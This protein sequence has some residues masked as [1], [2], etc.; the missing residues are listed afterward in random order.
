MKSQVTISQ[1]NSLTVINLI[2]AHRLYLHSMLTIATCVF[3][4]MGIANYVYPSQAIAQP[5]LLAQST[6]TNYGLGLPKSASTGGGTRLVNRDSLEIDKNSNTQPRRGVI[7][8]IRSRD[9]SPALLMRQLQPQPLLTL[10][11][12]ED[13][14]RTANAQPTLYWY[15]YDQP[16]Q[17]ASSTDKPDQPVNE[18]DETTHAIDSQDCFVGQLRIILT[19]DQKDITT[20]FQTKLT[21]KSGLSSF[22]LPI[23]AS[24]QPSKSY[25]WEITLPDQQNE[26]E[27]EVIVSG[28]IMYSPSESSLQKALMR[29]LTI[30]DRAKIYAEAGYWFEAIDNYTRWLK[31]NP[32]D[33]KTRSAR[34][35]ILKSGFATNNNLDIDSFILLL[36]VN[37]DATKS[38]VNKPL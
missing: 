16:K 29:A 33:L 26:L 30:R 36:N 28:W 38:P 9:R 34:N 14:G 6:V 31:L 2:D 8:S 32:N 13:G 27:E 19:E 18:T 17:M 25:R 11:T 35:E 12:P 15:L 22:K 37:A 20:I 21:M 1:I 5:W 4:S 24:L 3:G 7:P 23:A 10:I